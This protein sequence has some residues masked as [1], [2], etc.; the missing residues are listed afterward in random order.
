[1]RLKSRNP[2]KAHLGYTEFQLPTSILL[3]KRYMREMNAIN[4]KTPYKTLF[5]GLRWD[6]MRLKSREHQKAHQ[7]PL[8]HTKFQLPILILLGGSWGLCE[9]QR[10]KDKK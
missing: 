5:P 3:E 8:L 9:K 6:V 7:R 2:R 10:N 1:M 4:E